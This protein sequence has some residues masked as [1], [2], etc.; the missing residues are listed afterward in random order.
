[1]SLLQSF[2]KKCK[3]SKRPNESHLILL[4]HL[5]VVWV[6]SMSMYCV[7]G[8]CIDSYFAQQDC[9]YIEKEKDL[10]WGFT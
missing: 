7:N 1:M 9:M 10:L 4:K 6:G 5:V 3:K 8:L 2:L